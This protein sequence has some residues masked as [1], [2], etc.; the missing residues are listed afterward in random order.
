[1]RTALRC[2]HSKKTDTGSHEKCTKEEENGIIMKLFEYD[3]EIEKNPNPITTYC[4]YYDE[5]VSA[6][7]TRKFLGFTSYW[8][9]R[10]IESYNQFHNM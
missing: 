6:I 2:N 9:Q 7:C 10:S 1:M 5:F 4:H 3:Y 8:K